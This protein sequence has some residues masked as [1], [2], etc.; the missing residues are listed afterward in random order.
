MRLSLQTDAI[1]GYF[2]SVI[3]RLN[4]RRTWGSRESVLPFGGSVNVIVLS[5]IVIDTTYPP[6]IW[7]TASQPS[8]RAGAS[9]QSFHG[10]SMALL[11]S[12]PHH[13]TLHV[14]RSFWLLTPCLGDPWTS[15]V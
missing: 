14:T 4:L 12:S 6:P 10:P 2:V 3:T 11:L 5:I 1:W 15:V 7:A 8:H 13:C 9:P